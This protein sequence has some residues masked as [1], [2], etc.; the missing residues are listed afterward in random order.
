MMSEKYISKPIPLTPA[1]RLCAF[2]CAEL[3]FHNVDHSGASFQARIFFNNADADEATPRDLEHGYAGCFH[4]FGHGKCWG[5]EGHCEASAERRPFDL[6]S[7]H[8]L[9]PRE[10]E[11]V[12]TDAL[13][14]IA[15]QTDQVIVTVVPIVMA[16][17]DP[18]DAKDCFHFENLS[19]L[20]RSSH[21]LLED[22]FARTGA[23]ASSIPGQSPV[24]SAPTSGTKAK[25]RRGRQN[26]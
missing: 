5:D 20:V 11:V 10:A 17:M 22:P 12:V 6:R 16:T 1:I 24:T 4:V 19:L 14:R 15:S 26:R 21:G 3:Q 8:P 7:P 23:T 25:K 13:R 2:E 18:D 9:T